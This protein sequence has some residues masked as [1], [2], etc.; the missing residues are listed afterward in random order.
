MIRT[1]KN[2]LR[3]LIV[4]LLI[5]LAFHLMILFEMIPFEFVWAGKLQSVEE[6]RRFETVSIL[7]NVFMLSIFIV[8]YRLLKRDKRNR[9][10]DVLIWG[11]MVLFLLNTIGNLFAEN[12]LELV[13]GTLLTLLSAVLCFVVVKK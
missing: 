7:L 13:L 6:M 11:F 4:I 9:L 10:I 5:V 8:K 2:A 1:N 3:L 12:L